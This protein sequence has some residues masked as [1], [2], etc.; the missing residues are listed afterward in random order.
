M[1][2][3]CS[4]TV[5]ELFYSCLGKFLDLTNKNTYKDELFSYFVLKRGSPT[6]YGL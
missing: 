5:G 1:R 6:N 3:F 4:P 2:L